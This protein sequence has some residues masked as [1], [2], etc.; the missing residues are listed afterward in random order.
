MPCS[1]INIKAVSTH[2][3]LMDFVEGYIEIKHKEFE[4]NV[5]SVMVLINIMLSSTNC[6]KSL[7][8]VAIIVV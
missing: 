2:K 5:S 6:A 7:S 3:N 1:P 8:P 4:S